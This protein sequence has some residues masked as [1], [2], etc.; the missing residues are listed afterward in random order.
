MDKGVLLGIVGGLSVLVIFSFI[1]YGN[2]D[3]DVQLINQVNDGEQPSALFAQ[4]DIE[5]Q[6]MQ[7]NAERR[8][9]TVVMDRK[10]WGNGNLAQP[11]DYMYYTENYE[12]DLEVIKEMENIRKQYV[13]KEISKDHF[14][15]S[16]NHYKEYFK[17]FKYNLLF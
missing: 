6:K 2:S 9:Q 10:N 11:K 1:I 3:F 13:K 16:I 8:Y 5:T 17:L 12:N 15:T 4:I 14:L 7:K